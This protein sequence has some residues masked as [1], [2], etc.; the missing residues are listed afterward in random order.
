[1][2]V[3]DNLK[4]ELYAQY[5]DEIVSLIEQRRRDEHPELT[6]E[7]QAQLDAVPEHLRVSYPRQRLL[8]QR[9]DLC[10]IPLLP[11][12]AKGRCERATSALP[13]VETAHEQLERERENLLDF[14]AE[15][16][17]EDEMK[18][19]GLI[20][21]SCLHRQMHRLQEESVQRLQQSILEQRRSQAE[22][23]L[24]KSQEAERQQAPDG[25]RYPEGQPTSP[26]ASPNEVGVGG[27]SQQQSAPTH[28]EA[29]AALSLR[30]MAAG[31]VHGNAYHEQRMSILAKF[32]HEIAVN[33]VEQLAEAL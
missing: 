29:D 1:M 24:Q 11:V 30:I 18:E 12:Y 26:R 31:G 25:A 22:R 21:T 2:S 15:M 19:R 16:A 4:H 17:T 13:D 32:Q 23:R 9:A 10:P 6:E 33:K 8:C 27:K 20:Y 28:A 5:A 14:L 3:L 7:E